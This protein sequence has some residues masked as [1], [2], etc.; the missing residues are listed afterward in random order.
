MTAIAIPIVQGAGGTLTINDTGGVSGVN[1]S[2]TVSAGSH[3]ITAPVSLANGVTVTTATSTALSMTGGIG[4][5]GGSHRRR[6][7]ITDPGRRQHVFGQHHVSGGT[8]NVTGSITSTNVDGASGATL[9]ANGAT[10]GGL[11]TTANLTA[12]GAATFAGT[13]T[14]AGP[15]A[16]TLASVSIGSTGTVLVTDPGTGT[17]PTARSLSPAA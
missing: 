7:G 16:L 11:A 6:L 9:H 8:L 10:N 3:A 1:P 4:G 15:T 12:N 14:V 2:I 17:M 5:T 13:P